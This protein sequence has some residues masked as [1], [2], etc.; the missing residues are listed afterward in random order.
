MGLVFKYGSEK[1]V[2]PG[3][4]ARTSSDGLEFWITN[5]LREIH[6]KA[7]NIKH[8]VGVLTG[9]D[10]IKLTEANL[11]PNSPRGKGPSMQEVLDP[12]LPVL[13]VRGRS[14]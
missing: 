2:I 9:H 13:R 12:V 3:P 4:V 7:D 6:D 14:T 10:E 5:K 11:V 1:D 8:K